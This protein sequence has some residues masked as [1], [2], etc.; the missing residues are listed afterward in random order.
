MTNKTGTTDALKILAREEGDDPELSMLLADATNDSQV[1]ELLYDARIQKGYTQDKLAKKTGTPQSVVSQLE[2]ADYDSQTLAT[3][4]RVAKALGFRIELRLVP[5]EATTESF[6]AQFRRARKAARELDET[7]RRAK[8]ARY[9]ENQRALV[10]EVTDGT[11]VVIPVDKI[12][13]LENA[14]AKELSEVKVGPQGRS[15]H[16]ESLDVDHSVPQLIDGVFGTVRWMEMEKKKGAP[17][18]PKD[19][20]ND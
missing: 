6:D 11:T 9:V 1:A 2:D 10:I 3:I 13:G 5:V 14:T 20:K 7:E 12:Q 19:T 18:K 17:L 16:W 4:R 8:S 15:V